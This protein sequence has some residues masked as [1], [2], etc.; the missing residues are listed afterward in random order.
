MFAHNGPYGACLIGRVVKV[1]HRGAAPG[2]KC[3]VYEC[4]VLDYVISTCTVEFV[5]QNVALYE[6]QLK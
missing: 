1:T 2:T 6:M 3:D 5:R 4:L